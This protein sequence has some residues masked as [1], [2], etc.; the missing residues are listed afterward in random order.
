MSEDPFQQLYPHGLCFLHESLDELM[1]T[2]L[3]AASPRGFLSPLQRGGFLVV[4]KTLDH[5]LYYLLHC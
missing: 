4:W 1:P 5:F 2:G 3:E